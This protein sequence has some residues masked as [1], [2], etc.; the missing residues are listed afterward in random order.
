MSKNLEARRFDTRP[1]GEEPD[2]QREE[3]QEKP[4]AEKGAI[5]LRN[6]E[7]VSGVRTH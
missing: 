7:E 4:Q 1:S 3:L 2:Q 5:E 6:S